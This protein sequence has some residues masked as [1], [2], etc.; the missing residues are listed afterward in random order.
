MDE[1]PDPPS[2]LAS[3]AE[4]EQSLVLLRDGVVEGRLTLEEFSDR[5]G[6]AQAARTD[7]ELIALTVD[8]PELPSPPPPQ[9][10]PARYRA[11]VSKL[12]RRGAW[13]IPARSKW[14]CV[15]GTIVWT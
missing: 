15:C 14:R 2:I 5:V 7:R 4:R 8:L 6:R 13:E 3:D 11:T 10:V 1:R 12:V 9:T